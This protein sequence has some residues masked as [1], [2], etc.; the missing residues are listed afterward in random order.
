[1]TDKTIVIGCDHA[2]L[3]LKN[4][5]IKHL[6]EQGLEIEDIGTYSKNS[7]DYPVIAKEVA[8]YVS[9][10]KYPKGILVCGTG[11][12]MSI[13]A[14]KTKGVRAVTVSDTTSARCSRSHND[15]NVL[16]LGARIIGEYLAKDIVD[17][18]LKTEFLGDR[19]AQR[20]E[21]FESFK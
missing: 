4:I 18:W 16:C 21:M 17:I 14:C 15:A 10:G 7:C 11:L 6:E 8:S 13:V 19:H 2:G 20:V 5:I 9:E 12:G 3:D 1:M